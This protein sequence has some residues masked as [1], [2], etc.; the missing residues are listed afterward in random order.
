MRWYNSGSRRLDLRFCS[1]NSSVERIVVCRELLE[2]VDL[3]HQRHGAG[4][5]I[6]LLCDVETVFAQHFLLSGIHLDLQ[7][8]E[9]C[10]IIKFGVERSNVVTAACI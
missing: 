8:S 1:G 9:I 2:G 3:L 10:R 6:C 4:V 7:C 5:D